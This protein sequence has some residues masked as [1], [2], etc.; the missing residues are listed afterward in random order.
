[1]IDPD[2]VDSLLGPTTNY[3]SSLPSLTSGNLYVA[4]SDSWLSTHGYGSITVSSQNV[5]GDS[6]VDGTVSLDHYTSYVSIN[7]EELVIQSPENVIADNLTGMGVT[8][9]VDGSGNLTVGGSIYSTPEGLQAT[10][11]ANSATT[12]CAGCAFRRRGR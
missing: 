3:N 4:S 10:V 12:L 8:A 9:G 1:M 5:L 7:D 6:L 11:A 2:Y